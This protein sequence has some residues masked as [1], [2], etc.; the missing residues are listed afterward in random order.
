LPSCHLRRLLRS[1]VERLVNQQNGRLLRENQPH[2]IKLEFDDFDSFRSSCVDSIRLSQVIRG[3][4]SQ[5]PKPLSLLIL[6]PDRGSRGVMRTRPLGT[7]SN[8]A[9]GGYD[10]LG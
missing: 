8:A 1:F 4:C 5:A 10:S 3:C 6:L 2:R 7:S 9:C